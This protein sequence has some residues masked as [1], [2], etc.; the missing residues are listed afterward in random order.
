MRARLPSV[1]I[2]GPTGSPRVGGPSGGGGSSGL[3][4]GSSRVRARRR[5]HARV[6]ASPHA[7]PPLPS[8]LSCST[9]AH[10]IPVGPRTRPTIPSPHLVPWGRS[11]R[12]GGSRH[13]G[14][15]SRSKAK[16]KSK[17]SLTKVK[18]SSSGS[19]EVAPGSVDHS[20]EHGGRPTPA[21][22]RC[23]SVGSSRAWPCPRLGR[24]TRPP[25]GS[26]PPPCWCACTGWP[27]VSC[28]RRQRMST[29]RSASKGSW[30]CAPTW[31]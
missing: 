12:G 26:C 28:R 8:T 6:R 16:V 7:R 5:V 23:P 13:K 24:A 25:R 4:R 29:R 31:R 15:A 22:A 30:P 21:R 11:G 17:A 14:K 27:W 9:G 1:P 3:G 2:P 10:L 20:G 18:M 19:V